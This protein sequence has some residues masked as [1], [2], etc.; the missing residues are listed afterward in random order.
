MNPYD[1][2]RR[3]EHDLKLLLDPSGWPISI[4]GKGFCLKRWIEKENRMETARLE[5]D[6]T[7]GKYYFYPD[8]EKTKTVE[9][10]EELPKKLIKEGWLAD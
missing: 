5:F 3:R 7:D 6:M 1:D 9:G 2:E 4:W 8:Y 10:G